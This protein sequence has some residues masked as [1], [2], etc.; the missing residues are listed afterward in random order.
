MR[1]NMYKRVG[2]IEFLRFFFAIAIVVFH[3]HFFLGNQNCLLIGGSLAVEF[4][5]IVS[6]F[7]MM[8]SIQRI[9]HS[10]RLGSET[11]KFLFKKIKSICPEF[12]V[13]WI[14]SFCVYCLFETPDLHTIREQFRIRIW[15]GM[16]LKSTG[17]GDE[18]CNGVLWFISSMLICMA[19]LYPLLCKWSDMVIHVILPLTVVLIYGWLYRE[20][21]DLRGPLMWLGFTYKGNLRCFADLSLGVLCNQIT[22]KLTQIK[23]T[24]ISRIIITIFELSSYLLIFCYMRWKPSRVDYFYI[25]LMSLAIVCSFSQMGFDSDFFNNKWSMILGKLSMPLFLCHNFWAKYINR[26][27]CPD[28]RIIKLIIYFSLVGGTTIIVIILS[29]VIKCIMQKQTIKKLFIL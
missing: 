20:K 11:T 21:G 15:E 14:I 6:G 29:L 22:R 24:N 13:A 27:P 25:L 1:E 28:M 17:L 7:L 8:E 23:L 12:I 26:I 19:I 10:S 18:S 9:Q 16:L 4:F 2:K 5:Y 3:T